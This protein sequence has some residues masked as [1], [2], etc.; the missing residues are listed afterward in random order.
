MNTETNYFNKIGIKPEIRILSFPQNLIIKLYEQLFKKKI[1]D[2][3]ED[4]YL[5]EIN[6][7]FKEVWDCTANKIL[8]KLE[9]HNNKT[10]LSHRL[11]IFK[12]ANEIKRIILQSEI[13]VLHTDEHENNNLIKKKII[14][15]C[16]E[17]KEKLFSIWL[18]IINN[19]EYWKAKILKY[20]LI[21]MINFSIISILEDESFINRIK[22]WNYWIKYKILP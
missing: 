13:E 22:E 20:Q 19:W 16:D 9:K 17:I 4:L 10:V 7:Y 6:K 12:I 1:N 11:F 15:K 2:S 3:V 21:D 5:W 8:D 14:T 18:K